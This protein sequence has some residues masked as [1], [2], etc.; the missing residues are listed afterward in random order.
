MPFGVSI[1]QSEFRGKEP[2]F[3]VAS[4]A[5]VCIEQLKCGKLHVNDE[6]EPMEI[7]VQLPD[8][9]ARQIAAATGDIPRRILEAVAIEAYRSD[10]LSRGQVSELLGLNFWDTEEFLKKRGASISYSKEDLERDAQANDQVL[11]K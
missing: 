7:T 10:Q 9:I 8:Q 4:W 11:R 3:S 1:S 5:M 2:K 6:I